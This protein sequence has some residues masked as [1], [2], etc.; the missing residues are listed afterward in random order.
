MQLTVTDTGIGMGKETL[1]RILRAVS[2][3]TR[4]LAHKTGLG[5]CS[6]T[7]HG[8]VRVTWGGFPYFA[9]TAIRGKARLSR[10]TYRLAEAAKFA[11]VPAKKPH[12]WAERDDSAV[13]DEEFVERF[14]KPIPGACRLPGDHRGGRIVGFGSNT[15]KERSDISSVILDLI[16]PKMGGR[17]CLDELLKIDPTLK[18]IIASVDSD[19][20]NNR[21]SRPG[22]SQGIRKLKPFKM[23]ELLEPFGNVLDAG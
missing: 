2:Y 7:G 8:I 21:T 20:D 3:T 15:G 12:P 13:D 23:R 22:W 9:A 5:L 4:G 14:C 6:L 18:V 11:A 16:M 10:F 19:A 1:D 17:H